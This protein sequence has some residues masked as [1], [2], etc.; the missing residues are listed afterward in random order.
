MKYLNK[1]DYSTPR[2]D[3]V[4][5]K[6]LLGLFYGIAAGLAFAVSSWGLDGYVLSNSHAYFPWI[7]LI[8]G[9]IMSG[10]VCGITGWLT[11]RM[12]NS[13]PGIL[14][15]LVSSLFLAWLT[16]ALPMQISPYIASKLDPQLGTLLNYPKNIEFVSRFGLALAWIIPFVL[17]IGV[18]Q[19]PI[20]E[21]A[22]FSISIFGKIVPFLFCIVVMSIGG[23]VTDNLINTHFRTALTS[24]DTTIQFV[25]D[26]KDNKNVDPLLSRQMHARAFATVSENVQESRHLFI[27][28]FDETLGDINILVKFDN[29]WVTC[30][31][32]YGQPITCKP[33][34]EN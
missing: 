11:S 30:E 25:L 6:R 19:L 15:W 12:G 13:L 22:V 33:A 32:L 26:N 20:V 16:V 3:I 27:G 23:V 29:T 21:P 8:T 14:F 2:P 24:L 18:T 34:V 9:A 28:G 5:S 1:I 17:I 7:V 31:V 4:R 10:I